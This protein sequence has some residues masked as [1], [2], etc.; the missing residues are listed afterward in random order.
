[1]TVI[2]DTEYQKLGNVTLIQ[3][4]QTLKGP[5]NQPL[6]VKGKFFG[7]F[8]Y[9]LMRIKQ[10]CYVV[11]GLAKPLLGRPAIEKLNLLARINNVQGVSITEKF[12]KLFTGLGKLP[13]CYT[14]KLSDGAKPYSVNV[15][16]RV[17][18][19][20]ME[21]VKRELD[22]MKNLGVIAPVDEPTE[23]CSGMVGITK[24]NGQ[25]RICVDLTKLYKSVCR[26]RYPLPAVEQILS[27]LSGATVFSKLDANS[28]FWQIPLSSESTRL[29]TF[30][31]PFGRYCFHRLPFGITSAPEYFQRQM[32]E[33]LKDKQGV[34]CLMDDVLVYGAT[35]QEHDERLE[36]VLET[37]SAN[38]MTLN[39]AKCQFSQKK[40]LFLGQE[41]DEHGIRPDPAKIS[42]IWT[43]PRPTNLPE[44]RRFLSMTNHLS[45]FVP[46]LADRTKALRDLLVKD[47]EWVW[48]TPQQQAFEDL[49]HVLTSTP[50]L[51]LF[52]P[53]SYTVVSADASSYG[54]GAVLLQKQSHG[55][56]NPV[57]YISRSM[58]L[59]EQ[60]YAQIE[61]EALALTWACERFADYLLGLN[62]HI[63][64]DHKPLV[65]LFSTKNLEELPIRVQRYR[66]RMMR[67]NFTISHVPGKLLVIADTLSRAPVEAPSNND[68]ELAIQSQAF[69][70]L[71]LQCLPASEQRIEQIKESQQKDRGLVQIMSYCQSQWPDKASLSSNIQPYYSVRAE[72]SVE[73]GLLM[74]GCRI[75][76]PPELQREMLNKIHEG[77]LGITKCRARARQSVWWPGMSQELEKKVRDCYE[78]CKYQ[79]RRVDPM[80]P[81]SLPDLPWQKVGTDL[82][83]WKNSKYL[84]IVDYYSRY[85]EISHLDHST[86]S[87]VI[88]HTK[89][90]FARHGIPEVVYSDN[91]PQ[92]QAAAYTQFASTY[93]FKHV[94]S[95]PYFP[96]S[97]SEAERAVATIKSLLR[98]EGDP[99]LALL[100]YRSTPL[101]IG[102]SP[103]QLLM[104]RTLRSSVPVTR[105]QRRP[106]VADPQLV[107]ER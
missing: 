104:S 84:L 46:N 72:L 27:Q 81:S 92:F 76:I 39:E 25:V 102:Y 26:E 53:S 44:L 62:F 77:H 20:L 42:A 85:I 36:A 66:L 38:G 54:L 75:V 87:A 41:I 35:Q 45:K 6:Q 74:R 23:W 60:R 10:S 14:I 80:L 24:S 34:V 61:K 58:T 30:I 69:V 7:E 48:G 47:R 95:S 99:Y 33:M 91:G 64:T 89:S 3:T 94:T 107:R 67:F 55:E 86:A 49:N 90:I 28:G 88:T 70:N 13:G 73:N 57:A 63:N 106:K 4:D 100:A 65:P 59:T 21:P 31:I 37:M 16:R 11:T 12:S 52:N 40:I 50:V 5:S 96:Q 22:R 43:M 82:F 105:E 18:V 83:E 51:A 17:A 56:L 79:R 1:V 29:T 78:C 8:H 97:N 98:K 101:E 32:S 9:G 2:S 71:V 15:P 68:R 19:S 93:Q 103:S